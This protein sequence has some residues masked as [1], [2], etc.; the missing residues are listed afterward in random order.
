MKL[1]NMIL[2]G[3]AAGPA[4]AQS[5][6]YTWR[7]ELLGDGFGTAVARAGDADRDGVEDVVVGAPGSDQ[8][9][10]DTGA[11]Y[12]F[13][14]ADGA[15]LWV[16]HG[17]LPL[18]HLGAAV[19]AA[20]DV[21]RDG[22]ADVLVGLPG[23]GARWDVGRA[24]VLSGRDGAFLWRL[25]GVQPRDLFGTSV[26]GV[27]DVDR[28]GFD[29]VAVGAPMERRLYH[30]A[31]SVRVFSGRTG[32]VLHDIG[33]A[34]YNDQLGRQVAGVGDV[35]LDL[36]P[37]FAAAAPLDDDGAPDAGS[38]RVYSGQSGAILHTFD[39]ATLFEQLGSALAGAGDV[40]ADGRPDLIV[41]TP[42]DGRAG[43]SS[44]SAV[45]L[46]GRD[47]SEI[48]SAHGA[49]PETFFGSAVAGVGDVDGDGFADFVVG[50]YGA[51]EKGSES[52]MATLYSGI[53]G[54]P[55]H[56]VFGE[57]TGDGLGRAV[58]LVGDLDRDGLGDFVVGA[59]A[60]DGTAAGLGSVRAHNGCPVRA[61]SFCSSS[62]SSAGPG[63]RISS[64]GS[65][66]VGARD[67]HLIVNGAVPGQT[68]QFYYGAFADEAPF[69]DGVRCVGGRLFRVGLPVAVS[70]AGEV[71]LRLDFRHPPLSQGLGEVTA[72]STWFFQFLFLDPGG[73]GGRG[74]NLSDG[75][76][77]TFCR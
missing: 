63:A 14:G 24:W 16:L 36:F 22:H 53:D 73:P 59:P 15:L 25:E 66:R 32:A 23:D 58:A 29:D 34:D 13:S 52:G 43:A 2:L 61:R 57:R 8:L 31:G 41:G 37:D 27:G 55:M 65:S 50:G 18:D 70:P 30:A 28:D 45:V 1:Y 74:F 26:A 68:G 76:R 33:G 77:V 49:G 72:G 17:E 10:P 6:L 12:L 42:F 7:G 60:S 44:G 62:Q 40:D 75:L 21:D 19:A 46:S 5:G 56:S 38:V 51:D 67:F 3:A 20:G 69:G 39:G 11:V 48:W 47:G 71:R 4:S 9:G 64:S 54:A 35:D